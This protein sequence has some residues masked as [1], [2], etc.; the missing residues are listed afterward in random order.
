MIRLPTSFQLTP[1]TP[2]CMRTESSDP[3]NLRP[4]PHAFPHLASLPVFLRRLSGSAS[5]GTGRRIAA[6]RISSLVDRARPFG[7]RLQSRVQGMQSL[8]ARD[9]K[10]AR[11]MAA[12][13]PRGHGGWEKPPWEPTGG[14]GGGAPV[15]G[16]RK[17]RQPLSRT[18]G[19]GGIAPPVGSQG[20]RPQTKDSNSATRASMARLPARQKSSSSLMPTASQALAGSSE[21]PLDSS[22]R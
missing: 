9:S 14:D 7:A 21:P 11:H 17:G 20:G 6:C 13:G 16:V 1:S 10:G 5:P 2:Q 3:T 15:N 8:G 19:T 18:G 4:P 22:S 12:F